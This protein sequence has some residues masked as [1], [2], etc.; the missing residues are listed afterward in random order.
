MKLKYFQEYKNITKPYYIEEPFDFIFY[1]PIGF[2]WVR[3]LLAKTSLTPNHISVLALFMGILAGISFAFG[4]PDSLMIGAVFLLVYCILDCCDGMLMRLKGNGSPYGEMIDMLVDFCSASAIF[5]GLGIGLHHFYDSPE[6]P[7]TLLVFIAGACLFIH[8]SV[9]NY[10]SV[11][12]RDSTQADLL[13]RESKLNSIAE[14]L[15]LMSQENKEP[16][17]QFLYWA[18]LK[19]RRVQS[20]IAPPQNDIETYCEKNKLSIFLWGGIAGSTHLA[21]L[22]LSLLFLRPEWY[23]GFSIVIANLWLL[24]VGIIQIKTNYAP[25]KTTKAT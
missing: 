2:F 24:I 19:Y 6:Y 22:T 10:F 12:Y 13:A 15:K 4:T 8:V 25:L 5:L 1:R 21:I 20:H 17:S 23:L 3:F 11:L 18:Y 14:N 16:F 7:Y 9:Y